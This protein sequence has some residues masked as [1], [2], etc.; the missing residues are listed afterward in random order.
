M[1]RLK[2]KALYW[3][4]EG[5]RDL[6]DIAKGLADLKKQINRKLN[7]KVHDLITLAEN[8]GAD[9]LNDEVHTLQ[10]KLIQV[11]QQKDKQF[12]EKE[13]TSAANSK[14]KDF[15]RSRK[16]CQLICLNDKIVVSKNL[17]SY[18]ALFTVVSYGSLMDYAV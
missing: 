13:S 1:S 6:Y 10:F 7:K 4:E 11:E 18:Q 17:Q 15:L 2:T 8:Y 16:K 12:L 3:L 5:T 9:T 14:V